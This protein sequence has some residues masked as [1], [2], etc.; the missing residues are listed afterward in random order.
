MSLRLLVVHDPSTSRIGGAPRQRNRTQRPKQALSTIQRSSRM[1]TSHMIHLLL[2]VIE[3]GES[4]HKMEAAAHL[5]R[6]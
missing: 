3:A 5:D 6:P 4:C 2:H 1:H